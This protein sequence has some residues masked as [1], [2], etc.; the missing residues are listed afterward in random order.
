MYLSS[1][2]CRIFPELYSLDW[3]QTHSILPGDSVLGGVTVLKTHS[4]RPTELLHPPSH[5]ECCA[6]SHLCLGKGI[7]FPWGGCVSFHIVPVM[8]CNPS[9]FGTLLLLSSYCWKQKARAFF[10]AFVSFPSLPFSLSP[11]LL[12]TFSVSLPFVLSP[13]PPFPPLPLPPLSP[14][15]M[16]SSYP[17]H[18]LALPLP[19]PL[20]STLSSYPLHFL[21]L[22]PSLSSLSFSSLFP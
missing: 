19:H 18:S 16:L 4:Y 1:V 17:P 7:F 2:T 22:T 14:S 20:S 6:P 9:L 21:P 5:M 11:F 15:P 8:P 10:Y 13:P 12:P 3:R